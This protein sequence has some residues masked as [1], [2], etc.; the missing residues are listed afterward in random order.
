MMFCKHAQ[1]KRKERDIKMAGKGLATGLGL[2]AAAGILFAPKS[3]KETREDIASGCDAAK[4][5]VVDVV[6]KA[7][8]NIHKKVS[9]IAGK[10]KED[11][12]EVKEK[13]KEEVAETKEKAKKIKEVIE[14]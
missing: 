7:E 6:S 14:E 9:E 13:A 4:D 10:T 12:A 1:R 5:K 3:G 8:A 11:V 2:G